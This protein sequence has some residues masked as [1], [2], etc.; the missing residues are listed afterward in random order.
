MYGTVC[1]YFD[2]VGNVLQTLFCA[3]VVHKCDAGC[4]GAPVT[5]SEFV[6][7]TATVMSANGRKEMTLS[8]ANREAK[9]RDCVRPAVD[10]QICVA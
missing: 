3:A 8:N 10:T 5:V 6:W 9:R 7:V 4:T 2:S 1:Q